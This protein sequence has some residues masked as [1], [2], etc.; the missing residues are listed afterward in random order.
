[1]IERDALNEL[2][3][4]AYTGQTTWFEASR[5]YELDAYIETFHSMRALMARTLAG[6]TDAEV[7]FASPAYPFWSIS[8]TITHLIYSQGFYVN[9]LL[10]LSTAQ[11][12]HS[13]EAARGFGEGAVQGVPAE[14]LR[15]RLTHATEQVTAVLAETR[16][17]HDPVADEV[18]PFFG[19]CDFRTWA[20]LLLGHETDHA[21]QAM[22][23]RRI[24]RTESRDQDAP[25]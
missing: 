5:R 7:A 6:L 16:H 18:N 21:R 8:E 11:L 22:A 23:V 9:K 12:P 4:S 14:E 3:L 24:A 17:T 2:L 25:A 1:M 19:R 13:A 10:D 20:L 15:V